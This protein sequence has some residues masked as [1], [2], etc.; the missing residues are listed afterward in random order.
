MTATSTT[1][2][3][4]L[5]GRVSTA[6][7]AASDLGLVAQ[8]TKTRAY[9]ETVKGWEIVE[10][11]TENGVSGTLA[12]D[13]RPVLGRLLGLLDDGRAD[14]LVVA[15]LDRL[16]RN[17]ADVLGLA[18]RAS[19]NGWALVILDHNLDSTTPAGRLMLTML[20]GIAEFERNVIAARS[21]EAPA[22]KKAQGARRGRPET[23]DETRAFVAAY[24]RQGLSLA[25]TAQRLNDDG[26]QTA[27][28]GKW[29]ASSVSR[30]ERS[31]LSTRKR[32]SSGPSTRT[33][34][35][36]SDPGPDPSGRSP[37]PRKPE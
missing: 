28:G 7:Q 9:A 25:A 17:A 24:R 6:E 20:A 26:V 21:R 12:P 11:G 33:P 37:R 8:Q 5:Y 3:A 2:R 34:I 29:Y 22:A 30:L 23:S 32:P 35:S 15:R 36:P 16:G 4:V 1:T 18:D 14:V 19:R 13:E 10:A 27:R 31:D